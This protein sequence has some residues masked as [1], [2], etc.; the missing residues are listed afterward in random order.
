MRLWLTAL[1]VL[2]GCTGVGAPS[3]PDPAD[4]PAVEAPKPATVPIATAPA[5]AAAGVPWRSA[6]PAGEGRVAFDG[7]PTGLLVSDAGTA[8]VVGA[9]PCGALQQTEGSGALW[10][11]TGE[12]VTHPPAAVVT[13]ALVERAGWRL[14][15]VIGPGAGIAP[16]VDAP[17]PAVHNGILV[18][19]IRK[20]RRKGPPWQ[21]VVG[22]RRSQVVVALTDKDVDQVKAGVVLERTRAGLLDLWSLPAHDMDGDGTPEVLVVGDGADGGLRAVFS[23]D[24]DRGE[25]TLRTLEERGP[26]TCDTP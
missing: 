24:L 13:A 18:R 5:P 25:L 15:E 26:V 17:D 1:A 20:I 12:P 3:T 2:G 7:A 16:G 10:L 9:Q 21:V 4:P 19:S 11:P 8:P 23:V 14:A 6:W 22:E